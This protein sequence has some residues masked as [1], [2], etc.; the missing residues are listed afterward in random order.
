[1]S[2]R[3]R[4]TTFGEGTVEAWRRGGRAAVVRFDGRAMPLELPTGELEGVGRAEPAEERTS[5]TGR[6]RGA[7]AGKK[8]KPNKA[9][10]EAARVPVEL[11]AQIEGSRER[12]PAAMVVE[13]MRLGVVPEAD[14]SAYT[15]GREH[16]L[17]LVDADLTAAAGG[18]GQVRA[19]LGDYGTGKTHLLEMVQQR[20]LSAG[21]LT[22]LV[23][24]DPREAAP[25]HPRR[26]YRSI[27]QGLRYPGRTHDEAPGLAQLLDEAAEHAG[28]LERFG[29][30]KVPTGAWGGTA[31][32]IKGVHLYLTAALERWR[33]LAGLDSG[34][35]E[36]ERARELLE[37]WIS[38]H[39]TLSNAEVD[40]ELA[41]L[42]TR[43]ARLYSLQDFRP[44]ARIYGYLLTGL[45]VLARE[46]GYKG[47]VNSTRSSTARTAPLRATCF[48]RGRVGRRAA[49]TS[50]PRRASAARGSSASCPTTTTH[51]AACS[52]CWR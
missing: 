48:K 15:V 10:K 44:W 16:E 33:H 46:V 27:I 13:A 25:S 39:P 30:G 1:M 35:H 43:G 4:H 6:A 41:A 32:Q 3:V 12:A 24:L 21:F 50:T 51:A 22:S 26:V 52:W 14:L 29:I 11:P 19:F 18:H 31:L 38:G 7:A 2:V 9:P 36:V 40:R 20:A 49:R 42:R 47:L 37:A 28:A 34:H 23:M 45:S 8:P 17:A 5:G